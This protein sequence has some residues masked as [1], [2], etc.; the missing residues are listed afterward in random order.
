MHS[1]CVK[2]KGSLATLKGLKFV[3]IGKS[4]LAG[5]KISLAG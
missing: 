4:S 3:A 1:E 5:D 2:S